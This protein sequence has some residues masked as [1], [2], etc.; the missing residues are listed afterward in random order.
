MNLV[1]KHRTPALRNARSEKKKCQNTFLTILQVPTSSFPRLIP[2]VSPLSPPFIDPLS[3]IPSLHHRLLSHPSRLR[4]VNS[5]ANHQTSM[6]NEQSHN[7][8]ELERGPLEH[9]TERQ[10]VV[11]PT[12]GDPIGHQGVQTQSG[13][14]RRALKVRRLAR[15]I[16]GNRGNGHVESCQTGQTAKDEK[17]QEDVV[18]WRA[19]AEA[20]GYGG[21]CYA[22]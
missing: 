1:P 3:Y 22:K 13:G 2:R 11:D 6:Q 15:R 10:I 19:Q 5:L 16:F 8:M 7:R 14:D 20:E 4:N 12:L 9:C 17:G 18:D 21:W